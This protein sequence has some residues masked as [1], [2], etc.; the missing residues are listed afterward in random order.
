MPAAEALTNFGEGL[1]RPRSTTR[2]PIRRETGTV[3]RSLNSAIAKNTLRVIELDSDSP[4][5][6]SDLGPLLSETPIFD[7]TPFPVM[8]E[9]D[10]T[11]ATQDLPL[12]I[13]LD[14]TRTEPLGSKANVHINQKVFHW[15]EPED[16]VKIA[17][18]ITVEASGISIDDP[19]RVRLLS[20]QQTRTYGGRMPLHGPKR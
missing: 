15:D 16:I 5:T 3:Y 17:E 7:A 1:N 8:K 4:L 11:Q 12:E 10:E 18:L 20:K 9:L 13:S 14:A 6:R 2:P 19:H